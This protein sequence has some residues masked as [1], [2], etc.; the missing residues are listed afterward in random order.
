MLCLILRDSL[1]PESPRLLFALL[2][3]ALEPGFRPILLLLAG[4]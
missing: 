3:D 4:D 2:L 1:S